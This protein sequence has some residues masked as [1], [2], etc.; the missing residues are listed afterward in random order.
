MKITWSSDPVCFLFSWFADLCFT[1]R[2][3]SL[4]LLMILRNLIQDE[5]LAFEYFYFIFVSFI[6]FFFLLL[7][8]FCR[9]REF[10]LIFNFFFSLLLLFLQE[11]FCF[12]SIALFCFSSFHLFLLFML[13]ILQLVFQEQI[14]DSWAEKFKFIFFALFHSV[15]ALRLWEFPRVV[16]SF[17]YKLLAFFHSCLLEL[18]DFFPLPSSLLYLNKDRCT[19][20]L[21]VFTFSDD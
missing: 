16:W 15:C 6:C 21:E 20:L 14:V 1:V 13:S 5:V 17:R 7:W 2:T 19:I 18:E 12:F 4:I 10:S 8:A 3:Y 9:L 11:E